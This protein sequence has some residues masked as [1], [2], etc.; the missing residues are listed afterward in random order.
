MNRA[1]WARLAF[2]SRLA[3]RSDNVRAGTVPGVFL[4]FLVLA[5]TAA[6]QT[7]PA[8]P[9]TPAGLQTEDPFARGKHGSGLGLGDPALDAWPGLLDAWLRGRGLLTQ[10]K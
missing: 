8:K 6:A 3:K 2:P 7:Q 5:G 10:V 4:V 9:A 1:R